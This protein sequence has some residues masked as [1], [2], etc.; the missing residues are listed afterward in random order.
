MSFR[1][2]IIAAVGW[3]ASG[4]FLGQLVAWGVT[5]VVIRI[6]SPQDY[7]LLAMATVLTG[8][9]ALFSEFGLSWALVHARELDTQT[10]RRAFGLVLVVNGALSAFVF[11]VAPLVAAFFG[12]ARLTDIVRVLGIQFL[13]FAPGVIPDSMLQRKLEFKWRSLVE[14]SS[15]IAGAATT[16]GFAVAGFGVWSLVYGSLLMAVW[17]TVGIN[18]AHPFLHLPSFVF[19]GLGRLFAFGGYVALSKF[20]MYLYLSADTVIGGRVLG[21]EQIGYYSVGM[22]LASLPLLRISVILNEVAFPAFTH[23][24]DERDRVGGYLLQSVRLLSLFAFPVFWGIA[25]VSPEIVGVFLGAKWE[26]AIV[27]LQLLALVMP[28]RM[29]GQLM[30]PTLQGMGKVKLVV[31]NQLLAC[32]VMTVAFL[33]GVQFGIIGLSLAWLIAFPAI[34]LVNLTTWLPIVRLRAAQ[35]L[36]AMGRSALAGV[37]MFAAVAAVRSL[38]SVDGP[39]ALLLYIL[40][41]AASYSGLSLAINREALRDVRLLFRRGAGTQQ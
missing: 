30:S 1:A 8:F 27:P 40:V 17:R 24:Q 38:W 41:G 6:L 33:V 23:I 7:G 11:A 14:L 21:K 9:A 3:T 15:T 36:G 35:L 37:G 32:V 16:L 13:I 39:Y 28:V 25:A 4:R 5:F 29:I 31:V 34:F 19:R 18:M 2:R 20:L 12:E 22:S 26:P 10:L